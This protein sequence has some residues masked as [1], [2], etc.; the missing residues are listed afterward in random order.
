MSKTELLKKLKKLNIKIDE[1]IIKGKGFKHLA[2]EHKV[3]V[4]LLNN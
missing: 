2:N 1:L 4:N 3:I